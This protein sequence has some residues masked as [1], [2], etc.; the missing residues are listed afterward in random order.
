MNKKFLLFRIGVFLFLLGMISLSPFFMVY[1][2]LT[3]ALFFWI[4]S[5]CPQCKHTILEHYAW[6]NPIE[7]LTFFFSIITF[8][9]IVCPLCGY[10]EQKNELSSIKKKISKQSIETYKKKK[11]ERKKNH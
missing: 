8:Q 5:R 6:E 3:G 9:P 2:G 4:F 1:I 11:R 10:N 7:Q